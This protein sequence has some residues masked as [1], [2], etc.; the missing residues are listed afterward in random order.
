M[1]HQTDSP[2]P[3]DPRSYAADPERKT[4]LLVE[5][6]DA[7]RPLLTRTLVSLGYRVLAPEACNRAPEVFAASPHAIDAVLCDVVLPGISGPEIVRQILATPGAEHVRVLFMS[8]HSSDA[9]R[10]D[11][12]LAGDSHFIQKPFARAEFAQKL[13]DLLVA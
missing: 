1:N 13:Q 2:S 7:V 3:A 10:E 9:L 11:G 4:I 5:D 8:G 12:R 6:D